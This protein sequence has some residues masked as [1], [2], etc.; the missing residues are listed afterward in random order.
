MPQTL[1]FLRNVTGHTPFNA[2]GG[3][4]KIEPKQ[5]IVLTYVG[6][7]TDVMYKKGSSLIKPFQKSVK[8]N[9]IV[10]FDGA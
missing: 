1:M 4:S 5:K 6:I 9:M 2:Q 8:I 3:N 7:L 10:L